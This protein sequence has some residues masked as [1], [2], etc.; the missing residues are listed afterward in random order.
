MNKYLVV[1]MTRKEYLT[2]DFETEILELDHY[3]AFVDDDSD[4]NLKDA[5]SC[6][7]KLLLD[8]SVVTANITLIVKS[9][10]Y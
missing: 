10:D 9:T 8:D 5:T 2:V 3:K 7:N 6:Y 4:T 1:W